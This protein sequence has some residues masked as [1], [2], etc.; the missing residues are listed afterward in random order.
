MC[1]DLSKRQSDCISRSFL[2]I[3]N[4][5]PYLVLVFFLCLCELII[6]AMLSAGDLLSISVCCVGIGERTH[7]KINPKNKGV[8]EKK[9]I[10]Y[11]NLPK[12]DTENCNNGGGARERKR[13]ASLPCL[14]D[15]IKRRRKGKE[16]GMIMFVS[17]VYCVRRA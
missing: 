17:C 2:T 11:P 4:G 1:N 8:E 16:Q 15:W 13:E 7:V 10:E 14:D 12:S 5:F 6:F 9:R 3:T